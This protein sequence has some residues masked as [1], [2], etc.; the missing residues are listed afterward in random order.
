MSRPGPSNSLTDVAGLSVGCA[1]DSRVLTGVTVILADA[2]AIAAA[3][4][5]GGGPGTRETVALKPGNLVQAVDAIVLAG[6]SVYGLAAADAVVNALGAAGKGYSL[7]DAPGVPKAPIV[8]A[9]ILFDLAN[10]GDK[11]WGEAPPYHRLGAEAF[12]A[13]SREVRLG[14]AGA[15]YGAL[16]G[17][18]KGGQGSASV[19]SDG[20]TVAALACVNC[21]GSTTM[22]RSRAFWAWAHEMNGE[23][24]AAKPSL[25][26]VDPD[27]WAGAKAAPSPRANTTLAV[28]ATDVALTQTE[29]KR[30]AQM[31]A[32]GFARAIRPV[33]APFDGDIVF[34]LSTGKVEP[35]AP[36]PFTL[37]RIGALAADCLARAIARGI[38]EAAPLGAHRAW[39]DL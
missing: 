27:D 7:R 13:A 32:A 23:F 28:V 18:L 8:P 2:P 19:V 5:F 17:T 14:N 3:D 29:M 39:R 26:A 22:P 4:V 11:N 12:R 9:A 33:F 38:Y 35:A 36:R 34:A 1:E 21:F 25:E 30:V 37:A 15:G 6:G 16:A 31:A 24:G 20:M 10:G